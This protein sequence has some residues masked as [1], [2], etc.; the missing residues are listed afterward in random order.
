MQRVYVEIA[1]KKRRAW[2]LFAGDEMAVVVLTPPPVTPIEVRDE[3]ISGGEKFWV[4]AVEDVAARGEEIRLTVGRHP[5][6]E[7]LVEDVR[8][9][10]ARGSVIDEGERVVEVVGATGSSGDVDVEIGKS[11]AG[12]K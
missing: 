12:V 9:S 7:P 1:G 6:P 5:V 2:A 4:H 8:E 11:V 10:K 3:I